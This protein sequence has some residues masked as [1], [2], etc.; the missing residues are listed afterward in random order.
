MT[1]DRASEETPPQSVPS[2]CPTSWLVWWPSSLTS[3]HLIPL[4]MA[5]LDT[6]HITALSLLSVFFY[7]YHPYVI[8]WRRAQALFLAWTIFLDLNHWS[9]LICLLCSLCTQ[10]WL[11]IL[12]RSDNIYSCIL[13]QRTAIFNQVMPWHIQLGCFLL[14]SV[15]LIG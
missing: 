1:W 15:Y 7:F 9:A 14:R 13:I 12:Q 8:Q 10:V 6:N 3:I 5:I 11:G 2:P 4:P